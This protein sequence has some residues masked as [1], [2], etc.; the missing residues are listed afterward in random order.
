MHAHNLSKHLV[1]KP[2]PSRFAVGALV[3]L[4]LLTAACSD[5]SASRINAPPSVSLNRSGDGS[6][7]SGA[8]GSSFAVLAKT[9]VSCSGGSI[10]GDVGTFQAPGDL[11]PGVVT[12][13]TGCLVN[14]AVH[15]GDAAAKAAFN[16]FLSAY[17]ALAPKAGDVCPVITGTLAGQTLTPGTYCVSSEAKTGTLTL[18]G[19]ASGTWVIKVPSG[20]LTGTNFSVVMGGNAQAC[21]VTWWVDAAS[22]MTTSAFKGNILAGA[23]IT[24]TAGTSTG[25]AWSKADVTFTEGNVITGCAGSRGN[26]NGHGDDKDK[27]HDKDK[28]NQGIGNGREGCDPG[29]SNHHNGSNDEGDRKRGHSDRDGGR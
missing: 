1:R 4:T 13:T 23:G 21:N 17:A 24:M 6:S 7:S 20:A 2:V 10:T 18:S 28:C 11:P 12:L 5:D 25:N 9:A 15:V 19:P 27:D 8:S 14:G 26:G 16:G 29:N 22:T 3:A